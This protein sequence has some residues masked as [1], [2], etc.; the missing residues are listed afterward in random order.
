VTS[1]DKH[2]PESPAKPLRRLGLNS[3]STWGL[4]F[5][6]LWAGLGFGL[7][8][9]AASS[10]PADRAGDAALIKEL[11]RGFLD[12]HTPHFTII[13][14][15][16]PR[17]VARLGGHAEDTLADVFVFARRL[18]MT[19][20]M[21]ANKMT[22]VFFDQWTD[23]SRYTRRAGF[24]VDENVP[25]FY[26]DRSNRCLMFNYANATVIRQ[27]RDELREALREQSRSEGADRSETEEAQREKKRR[28]VREIERQI[29]AY[30][31]LISTT[32][33]RH[34]IAHQVMANF[35]LQPRSVASF[36][37][38]REGLAMQ[39]ETR[40]GSNQHRLEDYLAAADRDAGQS[41]A[42]LVS[43]PKWIGPGARDLGS[44]YAAAWLLVHYLVHKR[45]AEFASY[46]R[47]G[48]AE[49]REG[50]STDGELARFE[51]SFG[52]L[53]KAFEK[54]LREYARA[55]ARASEQ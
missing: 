11:G 20:R 29:E 7:S 53:D 31:R 39:F 4:C 36:R 55:L 3:V 15:A 37:W 41:L 30:Q 52:P 17:R 21:P 18:G 50:Q 22:V 6:G 13:S 25:G 1:K 27:K 54:D 23:Y 8:Q 43:D 32:V 46:L 33:V 26:D 51:A 9:A 42:L 45:P 49:K 34:E 12:H 28:R 10:L 40:D 47:E 16:D 5:W 38:L 2:Q 44:R 48:L 35:G 19:L 14:D 24:R